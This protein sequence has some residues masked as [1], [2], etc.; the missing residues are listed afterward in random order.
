V[1]IQIPTDWQIDLQHCADN[2]NFRAML[3]RLIMKADFENLE[4]LRE[5][6]PVE[7]AY[8]EAWMKSDP[9]SFPSSIEFDHDV[10]VH[11]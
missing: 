10:R 9:P 5:A 11:L 4:L 3:F 7:V 2:T 1:L 6:F 8:Y